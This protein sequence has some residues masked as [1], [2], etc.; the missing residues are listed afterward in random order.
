MSDP[1]PKSPADPFEQ[2]DPIRRHLRT[3]H[4]FAQTTERE[5]EFAMQLVARGMAVPDAIWTQIAEAATT[6]IAA[7]DAAQGP[8]RALGEFAASR[9]K[10]ALSG[11]P[12]CAH[13]FPRKLWG[14]PAGAA[15]CSP[16]TLQQYCPRCG[17]WHNG[18]TWTPAGDPNP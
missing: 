9:A 7:A 10:Q 12:A 13:P 2:I 1:P 4:E 17:A 11:Q 16:L 18:Q 8:A 3:S 14:A 15:H 5:I 6:A